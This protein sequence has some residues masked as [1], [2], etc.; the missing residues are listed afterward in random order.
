M[1]D[2]NVLLD[3]K[4]NLMKDSL[5]VKWLRDGDPNTEFLMALHHNRELSKPIRS[6]RINTK[7]VF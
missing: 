2:L 1:D 7:M 6:L 4:Y 5:K 3:K